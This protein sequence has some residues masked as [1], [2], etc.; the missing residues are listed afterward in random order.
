MREIG[1]Y[2]PFVQQSGT[3]QIPVSR[4][5]HLA[6]GNVRSICIIETSI[7]LRNIIVD[8]SHDLIFIN[9]IHVTYPCIFTIT[10]KRIFKFLLRERNIACRHLLI[11]NV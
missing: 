3:W 7:K 10:F 5:S 6:S 2:Q 9:H 4:L 11:F 8:L 1:Q